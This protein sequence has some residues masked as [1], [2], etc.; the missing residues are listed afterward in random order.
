MDEKKQRGS[1]MIVMLNEMGRVRNDSP[2]SVLGIGG[3]TPGG[4]Q[5]PGAGLNRRQWSLS[6]LQGMSPELLEMIFEKAQKEQEQAQQIAAAA[7][8]APPGYDPR[9]WASLPESQRGA[10]QSKIMTEQANL[11]K[12]FRM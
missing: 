4:T 3:G 6:E 2:P 7:A 8:S 9:L 5:V 12:M 1:D 10:I 11:S